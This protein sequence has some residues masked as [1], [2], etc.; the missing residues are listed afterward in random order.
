MLL[1]IESVTFINSMVNNGGMPLVRKDIIRCRIS[2]HLRGKWEKTQL[3]QHLQDITDKH[4]ID[5]ECC[6]PGY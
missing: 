4:P 2:M 3:F 6:D 5:F 1:D